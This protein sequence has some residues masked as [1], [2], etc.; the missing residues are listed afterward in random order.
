MNNTAFNPATFKYTIGDYNLILDTDSYKQSHWLQYPPNTTRVTSYVESRGGVWDKTVFFGLQYYIK[1][2]L[3]RPITEEN[4]WEAEEYVN[5]HIGP[6]IFNKNGWE[7]ILKEHGGYLPIEISA[8]PEGTVSSTHVLMASVVNTDDKGFFL[9]SHV[10]TGLLRS[11][12]Y[13][14]T[15]ATQSYHIKQI[16]KKYLIKTGSKESLT[17]LDFRLHDFGARGV[18]SYE[19]A[20]LGG[21]AHLV[22]FKGTD[23]MTALKQTR[24][25]YNEQMAGFS[26]PAS[27]HSSITTWG[28]TG[29]HHA[30]LNMITKFGK[31]GQVVS[32]V[33]DSYDIFNAV[34]NIFGSKLKYAIESSGMVLVVRPDSGIPK[35]VVLEI[36]ELLGNAF[37]F[38][39]NEKGYKVLKPCARI[40]QGDGINI[41]SIDEILSNLES[42]GWSAENVFFGMGGQLL[43]GVNRDTQKFALKASA[44]YIDGSWFDVYKDPITDPGKRSKK[45]VLATFQ[46]TE[47]GELSTTTLSDPILLQGGYSNVTYPI[48]RNGQLLSDQLFSDIRANAENG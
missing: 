1:E 26:V 42:H 34:K 16:I 33:S 46:H 19:S 44:A 6:G 32:I 24:K 48:F 4:I 36:V 31:P 8:I 39:Y 27:E 40:L 2:F 15:V 38:T 10:E 29:E 23:T 12:W 41:T 20:G 43:Q 28:R 37:S 3:S 7:Y 11:V 22:N 17:S 45:G 9:P 25:Y 18:S 13:G 47:T 14:T 30:Y 21:A 5:Q 35:D